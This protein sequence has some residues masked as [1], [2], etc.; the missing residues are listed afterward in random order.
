MSTITTTGPVALH[1]GERFTIAGVYERR[2]FWQWLFRR[3][4]QLKQWVCTEE[5]PAS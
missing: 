4:R 1:K 2:T 3:P 5:G